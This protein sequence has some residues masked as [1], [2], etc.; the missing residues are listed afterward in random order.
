M[1]LCCQNHNLTTTQPQPYLNLVGLT[2][3]SLYTPPTHP[4]HRYSTFTRNNDPRGV[5]FCRRPYQAKL[6]TIQH[7]VNPTIF[8]GG[9]SYILNLGLILLVFL[10]IKNFGSKSFRPNFFWPKF[11]YLTFFLPKLY[12][13]QH[14][15]LPK[16]FWPLQ[17]LTENF[18]DPKKKLTKNF[19]TKKIGW[20]KKILAKKFFW[21]KIVTQIIFNPIFLLTQI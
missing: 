1:Q 16:F 4:H 8:L 3:L 11:F 7:N 14:F 15:F 18:F 2:R 10:D 19:M 12:F 17:F 9:G 6:T 20:P 13:I 5:K 21:P